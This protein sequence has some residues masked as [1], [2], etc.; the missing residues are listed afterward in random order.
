MAG[1]EYPTNLDR[2]PKGAYFLFAAMKIRG[3][4]GGPGRA[5]ALY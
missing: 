2:L 3:C 4:H 5:L 1:V